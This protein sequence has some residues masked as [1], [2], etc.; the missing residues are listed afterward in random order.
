MPATIPCPSGPIPTFSGCMTQLLLDDIYDLCDS[1][2]NRV[3]L[4]KVGI[5]GEAPLAYVARQTGGAVSSST[6]GDIRAWMAAAAATGYVKKYAEDNTGTPIPFPTTIAEVN[7]LRACG[8]FWGSLDDIESCMELTAAFTDTC[9][10]PSIL[11]YFHMALQCMLNELCAPCECPVCGNTGACCV[12]GTCHPD[13]T[14]SRCT[15]ELGGTF[16]GVGTT[17]DIIPDPCTC[18][19]IA[20][21]SYACGWSWEEMRYVWGHAT[22]T[23]VSC[24]QRCDM[25]MFDQPG[26]FLNPY[27]G[28][29]LAQFGI[30]RDT[31]PCVC[32]G[33]ILDPACQAWMDT[34]VPPDPSAVP[35][36]CPPW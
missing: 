8:G 3:N 10:Q 7:D 34:L 18:V 25:T 17:C 4:I 16:L 36:P 5:E 32:S 24:I 27:E 11:A 23:Y 6:F 15:D 30:V 35:Y 1:T 33:Y 12:S 21:F 2:A 29:M 14:Q 31:P 19:C 22:G 26:W 20:H 13:V 9:L 28:G